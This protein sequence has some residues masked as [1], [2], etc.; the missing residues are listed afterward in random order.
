MVAGRFRG[1]RRRT[2]TTRVTG[3]SV[4]Y[5]R[6]SGQSWP[7]PNGSVSSSLTIGQDSIGAYLHDIDGRRVLDVATGRGGFV[8]SLAESLRDYREIVGVDAA[9][10]LSSD[11]DEACAD[12][13]NV[14]FEAMDAAHL[15][16]V[17]ASFDTVAISD[18]LHH[19]GNPLVVLHEM[20]RVLRP[21]GY[22]IAAEMFRDGLTMPQRSHAELHHWAAAIDRSMGIIHRE[23]SRRAELLALLR[24]LP[25]EER[26]VAD[27]SDTADDPKDPA[28]IAAHEAIIERLLERAGSDRRLAQRCPRVRQ[29]IETVGIQGATELLY[30]ARKP[31]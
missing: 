11:F 30:I 19:L 18:S 29:R 26:V 15:R 31:G 24:A 28:T 25:L 27:V 3:K 17:D 23:T 8:R 10:E 7:P 12:L 5:D 1:R 21:G 4:S 2:P 22:L 20:V 16:F 14:H 13:R 9:A 6:R